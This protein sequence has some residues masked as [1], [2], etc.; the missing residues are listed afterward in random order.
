[1]NIP[2]ISAY[3]AIAKTSAKPVSF[4]KVDAD[5]IKYPPPVT[6]QG[7]LVLPNGRRLCWKYYTFANIMLARNPSNGFVTFKD[8]NKDELEGL[9][10]LNNG[11]IIESTYSERKLQFTTP[12]ST[13]TE[14]STEAELLQDVETIVAHAL[15]HKTEK[16]ND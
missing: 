16:N 14:P 5:S 15:Q 11:K 9:V 2:A 6:S 4:G 7:S 13:L 3:G 10:R 12:N 1:M 8:E